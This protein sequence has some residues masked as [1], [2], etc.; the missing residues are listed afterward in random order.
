MSLRS[1]KVMPNCPMPNSESFEATCFDSYY[2]THVLF[3][4]TRGFSHD[5]PLHQNLPL[6]LGWA[7]T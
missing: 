7:K 4:I 2:H 3:I 6:Q 1:L 5:L